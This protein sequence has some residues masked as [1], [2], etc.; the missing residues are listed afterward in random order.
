MKKKKK[1]RG[2]I[3]MDQIVEY[4]LK[5]DPIT[6]KSKNL[7]DLQELNDVVQAVRNGIGDEDTIEDTI[8]RHMKNSDKLNTADKETFKQI[9]VDA[10][11]PLKLKSKTPRDTKL[12]A[13]S[14]LDYLVYCQTAGE[15][16]KS[17]T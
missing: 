3:N 11:G 17:P 2:G 15:P 9:M 1:V 7:K 6:R 12:L 4:Y 5:V 8:R 16:K 14:I 10:P 13:F